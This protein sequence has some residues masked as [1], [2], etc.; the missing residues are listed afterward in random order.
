MSILTLTMNLLHGLST[1]IMLFHADLKHN[2]QYSEKENISVWKQHKKFPNEKRAEKKLETGNGWACPAG[3]RLFGDEEKSGKR[4]RVR[5]DDDNKYIFGRRD[6]QLNQFG[7]AFLTTHC[8]V[9]CVFTRW[10]KFIC[11]LSV[12]SIR[13][14]MFGRKKWMMSERKWLKK[15]EQDER[16][17]KTKINDIARANWICFWHNPKSPWLHFWQWAFWK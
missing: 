7:T 8:F 11:R 10:Y 3:V 13:H 6:T 12:T 1:G 5:D 2:Y 9:C 4:R 16:T 15:K 17:D 14:G